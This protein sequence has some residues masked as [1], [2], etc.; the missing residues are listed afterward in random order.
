MRSETISP[1]V[2]A[3][4]SDAAFAALELL[5]ARAE[6]YSFRRLLAEAAYGRRL[7]RVAARTVLKIAADVLANDEAGPDLSEGFA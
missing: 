4:V 1:H 5:S 6:S 3:A 2:A 7:C